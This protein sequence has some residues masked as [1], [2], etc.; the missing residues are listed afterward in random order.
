MEG[1]RRSWQFL[2]EIFGRELEK[3]GNRFDVPIG[4]TDIDVTQVSGKLWQFPRHIQP[5]SIPF[6]QF[7]SR[8]AVPEI[9]KARSVTIAPVLR[10]CPQSDCARYSYKHVT[11]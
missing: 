8:K 10:R 1:R 2:V 5:S 7:S 9:L 6:D 4:K 3:L 11:S